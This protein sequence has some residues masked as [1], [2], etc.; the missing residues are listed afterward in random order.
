M[1]DHRHASKSA[2]SLEPTRLKAPL[3][4]SML[5]RRPVCAGFAHRRVRAFAEAAGR[6]SCRSAQGLGWLVDGKRLPRTVLELSPQPSQPL[7]TSFQG[8]QAPTSGR[9]SFFQ[10]R[11]T[12]RWPVPSP[13]TGSGSCHRALSRVWHPS[14]TLA[15]LGW[16]RPHSSP[17]GAC[18]RVKKRSCPERSLPTCIRG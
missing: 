3:S 18:C 12:H 9:R 4:A 16:L 8:K 6:L 15:K 5:R 1:P 11:D 10:Q 14:E 7:A 2:R 17:L 13:A